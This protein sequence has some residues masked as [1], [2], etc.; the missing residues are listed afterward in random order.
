MKN[1]K[2]KVQFLK[3][4]NNLSFRFPKRRII[5][6]LPNPWGKALSL[7]K[8]EPEG[9]SGKCPLSLASESHEMG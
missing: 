1:L 7:W 9:I 2:E 5:D 6:L 8:R 3:G 4:N